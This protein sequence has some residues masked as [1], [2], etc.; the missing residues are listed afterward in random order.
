[1]QFK[2]TTIL[3]KY[4]DI[5]FVIFTMNEHMKK[6]SNSAVK[7][8]IMSKFISRAFRR[9]QTPNNNFADEL[10]SFFRE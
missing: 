3:I 4:N 10:F 1:M 8:S 9:L 6:I 5:V 2:I 7:P